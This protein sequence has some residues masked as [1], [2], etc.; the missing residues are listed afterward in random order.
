ML[1][2]QDVSKQFGPKILFQGAE[3][4]L[5][6]RSRVALVG[7]NG[8]GKST[9]IKIILGL[10]SPDTGRIS[11]A[12]HLS[13]GYLAQE[14][15]KFEQTSVLGEVMRIGGRRSELLTAKTELEQ[16]FS[17]AKT[18]DT[19]N[20]ERYGRILEELE[21]LNEYRL[22]SRAK[23]ILTGMGFRPQDLERPLT[24]FSG[25]WLMRVALSRVLLMD[26]DLLLL[27][28]PT[29][30]LDLESLLWLEDFLRDH[31]GAL[32]LVSHDTA[33][34]NRMVHEVLEIDQRKLWNYRGNLDA[35]VEQK[36]QRLAVLRSQH[37]SQ[38]VR[39]AEIEDF[40]RR[41]G[42]KATKARQAQSRL[43]EL[44]RIERIELP[45]ERATVRFRFPPAPKGGKEVVTVRKAAMRFGEKTVFEDLNWILPRGSRI[46]IVG[47]NG[48]GKTTLLRLIAGKL[49]PSEGQVI[50]GHE[51]KVGYYA[52]IQ[53]ESL[54]MKK[55]I[56]EELEQTAPDLPVS[57]V[58]GIAGA[59]LFTGT[60][61]EK[62]CAVLSGGEKARV[63]L[64]KLL[65]SPANFLLLDEPTNHLDVESRGVLLEAL[66]G[67]EGTLCLV[68]H[69]RAFVSPLVDHVL[70]IV[71]HTGP[72]PGGSRVLSLVETYD[73]YLARKMREASEKRSHALSGTER[74]QPAPSVSET[75]KARRQGPSNNQKQAWARELSNTESAIAKLETRQ[76]EIQT[77]L[78][79]TDTYQDKARFLAL[80]EEQR[81]IEKS[82]GEKLARW[83]ELGL[84]LSDN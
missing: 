74:Q 75:E 53:A 29:N 10:E 28:E 45:E 36:E 16:L 44:D 48:A 4:H 65:L 84:L 61:V 21:H 64:A 15:P 5:G 80:A 73:D 72:G 35:Y 30:H 6:L 54:D 77:L 7:P 13:I 26:P 27:D 18:E 78:A 12:R 70:E 50:H 38:Q 82:L 83:E 8:S 2:I 9:L 40:V 23:E 63:A 66:Q 62:K 43:K 71:P 25:G 42:A 49:Q 24:H 52:Q 46:A 34:V 33:F 68:S 51:I 20:L 57:Q 56:I 22:E 39:I 37:A 81:G 31:R 60:A 69:D 79:D 32:L 67:Y 14:V 58:R 59:F 41:F 76:A 1:H 47:V 55:S 3:A 19:T 17:E 11:R